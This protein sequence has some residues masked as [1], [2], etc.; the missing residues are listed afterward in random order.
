MDK[1]W[2][3]KKLL[4]QKISIIPVPLKV[5]SIGASRHKSN[6]FAFTALYIP[7]LDREGSEVYTCIKCKLHLVEGLKANMLIGNNIL[8]TESLTINL[9]SAF[10]YIL[11]FEVTIV[12]NA[13][14]YLQFLRRNVLADV[15]RFIPLK[16]KALI[17]FQ[18][19]PSLDSHDFSFQLFS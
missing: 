12:I 6:K 16:S 19:I 5:G 18:Q 7:G 1:I 4:S 13:R 15:I 14:N 3:V 10:A 9:A 11:S 17:N 2:L 8:C